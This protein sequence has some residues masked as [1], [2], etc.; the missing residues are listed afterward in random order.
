MCTAAGYAST[1]V[2]LFKGIGEYIVA[3]EF[4]SSTSW[5]GWNKLLPNQ[6]VW[7][8][9][10]VLGKPLAKGLSIAGHVGT[11]FGAASALYSGYKVYNQIDSG[12]LENVNTLD[13]TD[14]LVGGAGTLSAIALGFGTSN[15][16]GWAVLGVGATA[17]G[18][19]RLGM[20]I[21][22]GE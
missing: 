21:Y 3:G 15:P 7:R 17:Y 8:S 16:I 4:K 12:G 18:V 10:R 19:V 6:Q 20:F 14:T 2:S 13:V 1:Y 9:V 22:N 11:V 5:S